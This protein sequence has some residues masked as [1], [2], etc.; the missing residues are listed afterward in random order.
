[1]LTFRGRFL[2]EFL[3]KTFLSIFQNILKLPTN[4]ERHVQSTLLHTLKTR[5][6]KIYFR[7]TRHEQ[8]IYPPSP[9]LIVTDLGGWPRGRV[10]KFA[11]SAAGG[12]V[13]R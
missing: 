2:E 6:I 5:N 11:R 10:V 8:K 7:K 13:F 4:D 1:M 9:A 3:P 12:P